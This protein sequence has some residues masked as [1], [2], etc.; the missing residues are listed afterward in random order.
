[1]LS[2]GG[3]VDAFVFIRGGGN[4][5]VADFANNL[6]KLDLRAMDFAS[7]AAVVAASSDSSLGLLINLATV[8]G[9]SVLLSSFTLAN[10]DATDL[11]I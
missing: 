3:A 1:V 2:G 4:D 7:V 8:G 10:L 5:R 6:D 9:G 11:L